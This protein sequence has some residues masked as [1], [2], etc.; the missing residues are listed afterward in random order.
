M[1]YGEHKTKAIG[2]KNEMKNSKSQI[3]LRMKLKKTP[4]VFILSN[5]TCP[6]PKRHTHSFPNKTHHKSGPT[7]A[8]D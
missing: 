2:A 5:P 8:P 3:L 6:I 7:A 4:E 1:R